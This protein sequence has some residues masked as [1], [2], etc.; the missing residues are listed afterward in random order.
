MIYLIDDTDIRVVKP[1]LS[2]NIDVNKKVKPF[3]YEAQEFDLRPFL[4]DE[5]YI[6]IQENIGNYTTLLNEYTYTH[7]QNIYVSPGLKNTLSLFAYARIKSQMNEHDTAFGTMAKTNPYSQNASES[8]IARQVREIKSEAN[9]YLNRLENYLNCKME[10]YPLWKKKR[11]PNKR[12][13]TTLKI[14]STK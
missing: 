9:Q 12:E 3:I 1:Q 2:I 8:S 11:N 6:D 13:R 5:L 14:R 7:G 4:G 10:D